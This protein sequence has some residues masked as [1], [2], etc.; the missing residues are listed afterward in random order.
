MAAANRLRKDLAGGGK[1]GFFSVSRLAWGI[2]QVQFVLLVALALWRSPGPSSDRPG[3]PSAAG[4]EPYINNNPGLWGQLEYA[5]INLEPPDAFIPADP[6]CFGPISR[7]FEGY[8]R[9][10]LADM[11]SQCGLSASQKAAL[12]TRPTGGMKPMASW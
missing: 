10:T 9:T 1:G 4:S 5:R 2:C 7:F 8:T 11:F 12:L 6:H 3:A